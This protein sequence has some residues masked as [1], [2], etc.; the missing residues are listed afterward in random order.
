MNERKF[1]EGE[2]EP[3]FKEAREE[4]PKGREVNAYFFRHGQALGE[5][6][7]AELTGEGEKQARTAAE[8]L[9]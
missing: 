8:L 6:A 1:G 2:G 7:E 3:R 4:E 9:L 5:G